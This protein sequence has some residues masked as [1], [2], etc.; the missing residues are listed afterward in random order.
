MAKRWY[1]F[2]S[3]LT[4]NFFCLYVLFKL[5]AKKMD[6]DW[7]TR[8]ILEFRVMAN[9]GLLL[10]A[11]GGFPAIIFL[12]N[13]EE[14][15]QLKLLLDSERTTAYVIIALFSIS[16]YFLGVLASYLH[17]RWYEKNIAYIFYA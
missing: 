6:M 5:G 7:S 10:I 2:F 16:M 15:L 9:A 11:L 13:F 17:I 4:F 8:Y 1:I 14:T 12:H 3:W